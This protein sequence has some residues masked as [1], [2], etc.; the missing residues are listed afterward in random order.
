MTTVGASP[1]RVKL[2]PSCCITRS[3]PPTWY[4]EPDIISTC[5]VKKLPGVVNYNCTTRLPIEDFVPTCAYPVNTRALTG[6]DQGV[7]PVFLRPDFELEP[8]FLA[9][10]STRPSIPRNLSYGWDSTVVSISY[11]CGGR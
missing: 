2:R 6:Q 8:I 9:S 3:I 10:N 7:I 4:A 5:G 11:L 1:Y